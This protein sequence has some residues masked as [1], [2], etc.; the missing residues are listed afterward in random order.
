[1]A[2]LAIAA[3]M[4]AVVTYGVS[5]ASKL[6]SGRAYRAFR[7]GFAATA[8][9]SRPLTGLAAVVLVT[10]EAAVTS[11]C[12]AALIMTFLS[13]AP[14]LALTGVALAGAAALMAVL[15]AGVAV[16]VRR[17][18]TAPCACF[19]SGSRAP[20]GG[21]HLARNAYLLAVLATGVVSAGLQRWQ[22]GLAAAGL[23]A[24]AGGVSALLLTR[25]D[26][27]AAL[28]RATR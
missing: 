6:R 12:A 14:A 2:E 20:L 27:V 19:G 15:T 5:A 23:A 4:T 22:P 11:L 9:V 3:L 1:M 7:A 17:G 18:V 10:T 13:R 26:D 16:A 8:L 21:V 24:A 28:F 25:L